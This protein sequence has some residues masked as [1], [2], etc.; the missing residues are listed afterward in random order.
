M[1]VLFTTFPAYGH[2]HP[3][4]SLARA[5]Q[6][7]GHEVAF[8]TA[9]SFRHAVEGNGFR[10]FAAGIDQRVLV[11]NEDMKSRFERLMRG[12]PED[13]KRQ[14]AGMFV[15]TFATRMVPD[16][17]R[18]AAEWR[19]DVFVQDLMEFGACVA[20]EHLGIP[21]A[22]IHVGV[23]RPREFQHEVIA[24]ALDA[25]RATVG[26]PP[27][28]RQEMLFRYLNLSFAPSMY[29]G[30]APLTPTTHYLKP[31][32]FDQSGDERLPAWAEQLGSGGRPV[33]HATL[34]TVFNKLHAPQ[35]AILAG[36]RDEPVE[37]VLTVG[38]D[39]DPALFGPQPPNVRLERYIPHTLLF[40]KCDVAI[41]H[42]GY[43][44]VVSALSHGV[45]LVLVPIAADQPAS[46]QRCQELGVA[47]VLSPLTMTPEQVRDAVREVL[48]TPSYRESARRFQQE[49][50]KLPG[51]EHAVALLEKLAADKRPLL[52]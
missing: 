22:T 29:L 23:V 12:S 5:L 9:E 36:L 37:L 16:L 13:W 30:E 14:I 10:H 41:L 24:Q 11:K 43:N 19:P 26:L 47:R 51:L 50:E 44:S 32:I 27:D 35:Q 34:G 45:P 25:L 18:V 40:P 20:G 21:Y 46:A 52:A 1:R 28:P 48:A 17:L 6:Q 33:V 8:A 3:L 2:F 31:A 4:V 38:R 49:A 7:A 39:Q 15:S 42:G